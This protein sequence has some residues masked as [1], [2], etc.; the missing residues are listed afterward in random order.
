VRQN[1]GFGMFKG[2]SA[3]N[4]ARPANCDLDAQKTRDID[5]WLSEHGQ[6]R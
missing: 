4:A 2:F 5:L 1:G 6:A 3:N